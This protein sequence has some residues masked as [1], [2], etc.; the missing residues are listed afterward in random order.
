[1]LCQKCKQRTATVHMTKVVNHQK[2]ECDLCE[3]CAGEEMPFSYSWQPALDLSDW[4]SSFL[5]A[6]MTAGT[7]VRKCPTCGMTYPE[8]SKRGRFGCADCY[9]AFRDT[10]PKTLRQ[11]HGHENHT[12]KVPGKHEEKLA[13]KH[14]L[15]EL[16]Q[17]LKEAISEEA[18]E[19]AAKL[20][21]EIRAL[22]KGGEA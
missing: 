14:H 6:P 3:T 2:M 11:Y 18:Y 20:R 16:R 5:T 21:D 7:A 12:G 19:K 9:E 10:L 1:M 13:Q 15:E 8:F 22:E 17:A 4:M